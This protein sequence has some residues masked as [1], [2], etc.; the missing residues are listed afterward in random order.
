MLQ[1]FHNNRTILQVLAGAFMISFS[2]IWVKLADVPP[3]TS[4]LYRVFFGFLF[5]L[6][7]TFWQKEI[8][9][10]PVKN[11]T[12]IISCGIIFSFNLL[13]WHKSIVFIGPGLATV[14]SNFQ[15]FLLAAVGIL[16]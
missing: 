1:F 11:L 15:V 8:R 14:I 3:T 7:A 10:I 16:F 2:A 12:W 4:G 6:V 5:L 9:V 13:F